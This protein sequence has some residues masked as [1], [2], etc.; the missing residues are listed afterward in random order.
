[1]GTIYKLSYGHSYELSQTLENLYFLKAQMVFS[2]LEVGKK[3]EGHSNQLRSLKQKQTQQSLFLICHMENIFIPRK[4]FMLVV[5][6]L[7]RK[8]IWQCVKSGA[9]P[10]ET[11]PSLTILDN[12]DMVIIPGQLQQES[13]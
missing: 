3:K 10:L 1:M 6:M 7:L 11:G 9:L 8:V 4:V 2:L 13:I 12:T 5:D